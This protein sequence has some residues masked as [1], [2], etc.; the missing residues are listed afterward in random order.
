MK[1]YKL[2]SYQKNAIEFALK[3][4]K[5]ALLLPTGAGKTLCTLLYLQVLNEPAIV[6]VPASVKEVWLDENKKFNLNLDIVTDCRATGK[7]LLVSYDWLK[8]N[9]E[10]LDDYNII[11]CDEGHLI[12]DTETDRYKNLSKTIRSKKRVLL[13]A[14]YPV[15]NRLNEIFM[16]SLITDVLG[17]N[18]YA[19][20]YRY[21]NVI[22]HQNHIIKTIPKKGS[23]DLIINQIKDFVYI[24][25]KSEVVP[26]D[27]KK[28]TV[29]IR[30][31]L[32]ELQRNI[33]NQLV[34]FGSY[35]DDD[36]N[37]VC[38]NQLTVFS[39]VM[40]IISGFVYDTNNEQELYPIYLKCEN[41][42]LK[43]LQKIVDDRRNFLLWYLFD[44]E[45]EILKSFESRCRLSKIQ[46]DSRGLNLQSYDFAIYFSMPLSGGMFMQSVDRLYRMGRIKD[47]IS[48]V[49]V[50]EGEF[51]TKLLQML[52]RKQKLTKKFIDE[53]LRV[54]V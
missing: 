5:S 32:T 12:A 13:L 54:K 16:L 9:S 42:K 19:F 29:I 26:E 41:P 34:E 3:H 37:I 8:Y 15:E 28:E 40:Q 44:C 18:Y 30:F 10:V 45:G 33:I 6:I 11:V 21:F 35:C 38:K 47:V 39:K 43:I 17:K 23:F 22:K 14:G 7:I 1:N 52:D 2:K 51:G 20:L 27:V 4:P 36:M 25:D 53:L 46:S 31:P 48:I 50:P 49:L 24:V